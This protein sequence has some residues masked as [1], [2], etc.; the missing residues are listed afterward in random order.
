MNAVE[1]MMKEYG[2]EK[3]HEMGCNECPY[4]K[5][6]VPMDVICPRKYPPF[7]AEKQ[8]ELLRYISSV[9]TV[10]IENCYG[11]NFIYFYSWMPKL[12]MQ[13]YEKDFDE[14][15]ATLMYNLFEYGIL[16]NA[17]VKEILQR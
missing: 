17:K 2:V 13:V 12:N 14:S 16:D 15:L 10:T 6:C 11:R 7:T 1:R 8:F 5:P 3:T 9:R 4:H